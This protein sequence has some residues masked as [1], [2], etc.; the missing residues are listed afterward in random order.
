MNTS[1]SDG[2]DPQPI[3]DYFNH[4]A[5]IPAVYVQ[6]KNNC[7]LELLRGQ[8]DSGRPPIVDLQ[9]WT[10]NPPVD[11]KTDWI[12]GHYNVLVGYDHEHFFFM[13]PSTEHYY[14]YIAQHEFLER[15]HDIVGVDT[16]TWHMV[17]LVKGTDKPHPIPPKHHEASYEE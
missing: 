10:D 4:V 8:I 16:H 5:K 7:T 2:T 9:A 14:A 6:G 12:D 1:S 15:W 13:D 17:I 11:W 3:A